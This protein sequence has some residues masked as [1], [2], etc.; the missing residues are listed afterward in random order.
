MS[1]SRG[2][3]FLVG[4]ET[5]S[6]DRAFAAP[7]AALA[8]AGAAHPPPPTAAGQYTAQ[9]EAELHA[10]L[11]DARCRV[12]AVR[13]PP[14]CP[15]SLLFPPPFMQSPH[16]KKKPEGTPDVAPDAPHRRAPGPPTLTHAA[17]PSAPQARAAAGACR[18]E[19]ASLARDIAGAGAVADALRRC[20]VAAAGD[21][22][23]AAAMP[24]ARRAAAAAA[25]GQVASLLGPSGAL[26]PLLATAEAMAAAGARG[27]LATDWAAASGDGGGGGGVAGRGAAAVGAALVWPGGGGAAPPVAAAAGGPT[28]DGMAAFAARLAASG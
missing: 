8:A 7:A 28:A 6:R 5:F 16:F 2:D 13:L 20:G 27:S 10:A 4:F 14:S 24:A 9:Q 12:A 23:D 17:P 22:G 26:P 15:P 3:A 19:C 25:A 11:R 21:G 18:S 1:A